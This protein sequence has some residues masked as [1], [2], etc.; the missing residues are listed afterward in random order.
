MGA[1]EPVAD[2]LALGYTNLIDAQQPGND[3]SELDQCLIP[4]I[5]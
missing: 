5:H 2:G 1:L 3:V 4:T